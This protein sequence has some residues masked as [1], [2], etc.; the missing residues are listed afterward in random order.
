M[1]ERKRVFEGVAS[2]VSPVML[3][4]I[5]KNDVTVWDGKVE[6]LT[7]ICQVKYRAKFQF[8]GEKNELL[9]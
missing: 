8:L 6:N 7:V 9:I 3:L 1:R 5:G 2:S 4:D